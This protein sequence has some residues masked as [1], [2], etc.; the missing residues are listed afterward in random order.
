ME[1]ENPFKKLG[2]PHVEPPIELKKKV[3]DGVD[4]ANLLKEVST[5]FT[6]N[7]ANTIKS[8]FKKKPTRNK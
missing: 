3:M 5:L 1:K 7:Y 2:K 8:L 4:A 6:F